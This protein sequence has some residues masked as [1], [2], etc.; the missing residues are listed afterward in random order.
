MALILKNIHIVKDSLS[1]HF[2]RFETLAEEP[3]DHSLW[4]LLVITPRCK[5]CPIIS[6]LVGLP[7]SLILKIYLLDLGGALYAE[8]RELGVDRKS[9]NPPASRPLSDLERAQYIF[10]PAKILTMFN[11]DNHCAD[12]FPV[13]LAPRRVLPPYFGPKHRC[14]MQNLKGVRVIH[15]NFVGNIRTADNSCIVSE[16]RLDEVRSFVDVVVLMH[17]DLR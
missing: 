16:S 4:K 7:H 14:P 2:W 6:F 11:G 17:A 8:F 1:L 13:A 3:R 9:L 5:P 10:P 15:F 12:D